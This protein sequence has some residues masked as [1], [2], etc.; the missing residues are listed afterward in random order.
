MTAQGVLDYQFQAG[1][2]R[3]GLTS[4]AGLPIYLDLIK[5]SGI[6][7]TIRKFVKAAGNQGW[8]DLQMILAVVFLNLAGGDCVE[9]IQK[10]EHDDGFAALL[11]T[12]ESELLTRKERRAMKARWRRERVRV[13]PSPSALSD[14]LER[15][16]DPDSPGAVAGTAIIPEV[17][18]ELRGL[19][20]VNQAL[21]AFVQK[22]GPTTVTATLD[23][24]ATLIETHKSKALFC[25]KKFKAFQ[26]LNVWWAELAMM[27]NSEFRDGNVP[28][29][30]EQLRIL[31]DSLTY[32]PQ[33]V[34]KVLLRSD[35]AGYQSDLLLY[36]GEG[37]DPRFG[38]I[39]FAVGADVTAA[40]R[41]AVLATPEGEWKT[42]VRKVDGIEYAT[43]QEWAEVVYV[44]N[45][46][47]HSRN[48]ADYRYVAIREPLRQ[49]PLGDEDKLPFPTEDF[50]GKGR[51]KLFGVVTNRKED[52]DEVI[53]WLRKRCGK[54]E[55]VHSALKSD[56]AGGQMPSALF[57]AN[58]AWWALSILAFNLNAA[59][60]RLALGDGWAAMRMKAMRFHL[61][62]LPGRVVRHARKLVVRLGGCGDALATLVA[63]RL[64]LLALAQGPPG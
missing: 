9:D 52:G 15:F 27:L 16:H 61:I 42:L 23:M 38:V 31:I 50:A 45:W 35:T 25:Y 51:F 14:W 41:A 19:W 12:I 37:K 8:M 47:G 64:K 22:H 49:L 34:T 59:L 4:L 48:R 2:S 36:C 7:A 13:V 55:A 29:G 30:H 46:A 28:A 56:L 26:P 11:R 39:E 3:N 17:T 62:G 44:P 53:W 63:A 18:K 43:D 6:A 54:S 57:G 21:V 20:L 33:S 5:T 40:F 10:L 32:L 58:A 1:S 60:K 24:D